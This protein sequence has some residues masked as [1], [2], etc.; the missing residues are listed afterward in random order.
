M[1]ASADRARRVLHV[2]QTWG[3]GG[4][5]RYV[6]ALGTY[7]R[8]HAA[9]WE[10]H[11]AVLRAAPP[12]P[13][14]AGGFAS[15]TGLSGARALAAHLRT[16]RPAVVHLHLYTAL[17]PAVLA[18][19]SAGVPLAAHLHQP[20]SAWNLRHRVGW[21]AAVRLADAVT[22]GT[23]AVLAELGREPGPRAQVVPAPVPVPDPPPPRPDPTDLA[24]PFTIAA[25]G[26]LSVEKD[27]PTLLRA[28]PAVLAGAAR[29]TPPRPVRLVHAGDGPAAG[30]FHK[31]LRNLGLG[32]VVDARG[33]VP[34]DAVAGLLDAADLLVLP[35]RFEG[36]GLAPLEA[37]ARGVPVV[38]SDFPAAADYVTG[39]PGSG[40]ETGHTF[41]V[42]DA[43]ACAG[44]ILWHLRHPGES[45]AVGRRGRAQV[46]AR[47]TPAVTFGTLPPLYDSLRGSDHASPA[48][49]SR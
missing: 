16:T 31:T 26:R 8:D 39:T 22:A 10:P 40:A 14:A 25:V 42:G 3:T 29:L 36:L 37:M 34:H 44:R 20:L 9:G 11:L 48:A 21:R 28:L 13:G 32:E 45:A 4:T 12:D 6:A 18:C 17:L 19:W 2:T 15:V 49:P 35:S 46:A 43:A 33:A 1:T 27:W 38:V 7:L 30:L 41:P 24:R 47:F 23:S 5:E